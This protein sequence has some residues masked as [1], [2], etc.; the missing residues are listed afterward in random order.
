MVYITHGWIPFQ[1]PRPARWITAS[2]SFFVSFVLPIPSSLPF[3]QMM[4]WGGDFCF[5]LCSCK[6]Q[7]FLFFLNE[8]LIL[9]A[10][11]CLDFC[12]SRPHLL[13]L[14]TLFKHPHNWPSFLLF[15]HVPWIS[16]KIP[17]WCYLKCS[18]PRSLQSLLVPVIQVF[19]LTS[20]SHRED[21][22]QLFLKQCLNPKYFLFF[23]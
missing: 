14:F 3:I 19:P 10:L 4:G 6:H 15:H 9:K 5:V 11:H 1:L 23:P 2:V 21:P 7:R 18:F 8:F 12:S 22:W 13:I 16:Q 20:L 17:K